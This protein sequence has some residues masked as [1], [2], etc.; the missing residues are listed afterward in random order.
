MSVFAAADFKL[1]TQ[2]VPVIFKRDSNPLFEASALLTI[3]VGPCMTV[4]VNLDVRIPSLTLSA[5]MTAAKE[6]PFSFNLVPKC[7]QTTFVID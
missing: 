7:P 2:D 3:D 6:V 4:A 5:R 1:G